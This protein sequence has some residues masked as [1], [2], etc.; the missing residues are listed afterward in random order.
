[1]MTLRHTQSGLATVEFA[2]VGATFF[3]VLFG[4]LEFGRALFVWNTLNEVTRRGARVATVCP[5]N[6]SA[7]KHV[8]VFDAPGGTGESPFLYGL[9]MDNVTVEYLDT[10][11]NVIG[12]PQ[13]NFGNIRYVRVRVTSYQHT[14]LVP[15]LGAD[16][17]VTTPDFAATL[18]RESLGIPREGE[19]PFCFGSAG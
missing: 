7:I 14:L 2:I 3:L 4:V 10:G 6:H 15:F 13:T 1:M 9:T 8:A 5:V 17:T 19:T 16:A 12:D 11:A 18:P